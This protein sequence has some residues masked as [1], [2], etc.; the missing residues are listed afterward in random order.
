MVEDFAGES[1]ALGNERDMK[2]LLVGMASG[3]ILAL[4]RCSDKFWDSAGDIPSSA[5]TPIPQ[6]DTYEPP[7]ASREVDSNGNC[8]N[9]STC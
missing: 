9:Q 4:S 3:I 8:V 7:Q 2:Y 5:S 1:M 6:Q